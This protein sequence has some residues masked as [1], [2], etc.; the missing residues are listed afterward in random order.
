MPGPWPRMRERLQVED[1][2]AGQASIMVVLILGTFLL[3]M[4]A[5][6]VDLT[7]IW[8]HQ[9][10]TQT[11]ADAACQAGAMDMLTVAAGVSDPSMG[12][13][14]GTAS[15]CSSTSAASICKY[16]GFNG[17]S[18]SGFSSTS[19]S[20]SVS[21]TFPGS[22]TGSTAPPSS[23]VT[24]PFLTV[25]VEENVKTWFM[26]LLG[27]KYQAVAASCT[28]G[29]TEISSAAPMVVLS[30]SASGAL[31][32]G[33]GADIAIVGGPQRTVQ[34]NS[35]SATAVVCDPS[36]TL[37]TSAAGP[38]STG[39][40]VGVT[41]GPT[42]PAATCW[43][44]GVGNTGYNGG[45]TGVWRS[46]TAPTPD[47]YGSVPA[48]TLPSTSTTASTQHV[49]SY[50][51]DG[52]PDHSPTN[53]VSTTPH[54]GCYE[55]EPG[56]YPS[57][58]S[59][60]SNDVLIFKA[61]IYYMNGSFNLGGSDEARLATPCVPSCSSYSTTAWQQTDGVMF[62]FLSG[63]LQISGGSGQ[64]SSSRV[65]AVN[66]TAL[67]CNG[68]APSAAIGVPS[69]LNGNVL[70]A[71][72]STLGTYV[73]APSTDT[74]SSSGSRGL[75]VFIAHSNSVTATAFSGSGSMAFTGALYYHSSSY[76]DQFAVNG[77]AGTT[78]F[79]LGEIIADTINLSGS[80]TIKMALSQGSSQQLLKAGILQ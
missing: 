20:N 49:V 77:G 11:A 19:A 57:G 2:E 51:Q 61:G 4:L 36:G 23:V 47:P 13:T 18:G 46:P 27:F 48:P 14:A 55:F 74:A 24:Y 50:G 31:T 22:V 64:L 42:T 35:A 41:G 17:Y 67:T 33:G 30:P 59:Q 8:F 44:G 40:D 29:L 32:Y 76:S 65:D 75:L 39:G 26:A 73:G 34:V 5:F 43:G 56:Y 28:C 3:A 16:A 1:A 52:C 72:C 80:G 79:V 62:Y 15:N 6:A 21:W 63:S 54:S 53:Y 58:I 71:Q 10:S 70:V 68:S 66:S 60:G 69:T 12:F 9:Q 45:T 25:T 78:T 37:D 7:N 38:N